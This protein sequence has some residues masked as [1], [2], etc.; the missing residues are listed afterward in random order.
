L[1]AGASPKRIPVVIERVMAK[2]IGPVIQAP[3]LHCGYS[4]GS[5]W[6]NLEVD[7]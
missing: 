6:R 4:L 1:R 7:L 2:P 3:P 5:S